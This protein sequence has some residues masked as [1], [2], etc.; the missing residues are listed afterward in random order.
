[1]L[2]FSVTKAV[3][4]DGKVVL[5]KKQYCYCCQKPQLKLANARHLTTQHKNEQFVARLLAV[6]ESSPTEYQK[7]LKRL[8]C[9]G[10]FVHNVKALKEET[11]DI[12]VV[13]RPSKER[14]V[15]EYLPCI[16]CYGFYVVDE[17]WKHIKNC[18]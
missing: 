2:L 1:L 8:K 10:N 6:K 14:K 7:G 5:D 12:V 13:K 9:L 17:L 4:K 11:N 16:H 18:D 3:C 15:S